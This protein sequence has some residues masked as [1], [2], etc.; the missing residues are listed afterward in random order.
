VGD[1]PAYRTSAGTPS[2]IDTTGVSTRRE[3]G[4]S[5]ATEPA[6]S[7]GEYSPPPVP[8]IDTT[9]PAAAAA[10]TITSGLRR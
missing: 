9:G 2:S 6:A 4:E 1:A 7:A 10:T 5:G 8:G 3:S